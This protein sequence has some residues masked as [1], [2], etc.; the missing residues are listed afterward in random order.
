M[1]KDLIRALV[2]HFH[3]IA[4]AKTPTAD[5]LI[6]ALNIMADVSAH[7]TGISV[8][9]IMEEMRLTLA[10]REDVPESNQN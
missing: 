10:E 8:A 7:L 6:T 3:A 1:R 4:T 9:G 2:V 5:E